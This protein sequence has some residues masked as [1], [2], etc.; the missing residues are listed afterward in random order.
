MN[1]IIAAI[2]FAVFTGFLIILILAVPSPDLIVV[3]LLTIALAGW[4]LLTSSGRKS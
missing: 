2:A 1:R 4:D 3:T